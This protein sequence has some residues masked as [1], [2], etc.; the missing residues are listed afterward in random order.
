M[1]NQQCFH[2]AFTQN[3]SVLKHT[4]KNLLELFRDRLQILFFIL[5]EFKQIN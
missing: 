1:S 5:S 4:Q 2:R 3:I